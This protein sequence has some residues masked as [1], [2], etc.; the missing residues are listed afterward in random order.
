[1]FQDKNGDERKLTNRK[2]D[3][4]VDL[5]TETTN[6]AKELIENFM[7]LANGVTARYLVAK[8]FSTLRRGVRIP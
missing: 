1:M 3:V 6:R 5:Q 7:V 2:T 4:L 8:K